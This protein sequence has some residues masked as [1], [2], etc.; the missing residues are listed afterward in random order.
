M[1]ILTWEFYKTCAPGNPSRGAI[2]F[3]YTTK[4]L[5]LLKFKRKKILCFCLRIAS[6]KPILLVDKPATAI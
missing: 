5:P 1:E 4:L 6:K 2:D 3:Y